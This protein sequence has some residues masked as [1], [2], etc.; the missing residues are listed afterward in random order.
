MVVP[1]SIAVRGNARVS[2][3]SVIASSGLRTSDSLSFPVIQRAIRDLYASGDFDAVTVDCGL[4]TDASRGAVIVISVTERPVVGAVS[5]EGPEAISQGTVED[6]VSRFDDVDLSY[7]SATNTS[8]SVTL[9]GTPFYSKSA[10]DVLALYAQDAISWNR[11][12]VTFGLR[13][14][15]LKGYLPEQSSP[16]SRFFP[17]LP[18]TFPA[19]DDVVNWTT[20]G[21]RLAAA[22]DLRGNGQTGLKFAGGRYYW[23][24]AAGGGILD[25]INPNGNYSQQFSWNDANGDRR[26]QPG[27][28]TGTGVI[29]R[30]D[31]STVSVL[32]HERETP[33]VLRWNA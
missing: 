30:V 8:T 2:R 25:G 28:Q 20:T 18:R 17:E 24:I 6:R 3:A 32:G 26:F 10:L 5:V 19:I 1:D 27:E 31:T 15:N 12:T 33:V 16:A 14:E 29:S 21:P 13:F 4:P 7:S 11:L 23:V 9:Y 22:Y